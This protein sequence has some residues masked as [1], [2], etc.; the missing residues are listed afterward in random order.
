MKR[1]FLSSTF[2]YNHV[3]CSVS[4]PL[5]KGTYEYFRKKSSHLMVDC[6]PFVEELLIV[7]PVTIDTCRYR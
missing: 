2:T 6:I 3:L 1:N 4:L 7:L 5:S